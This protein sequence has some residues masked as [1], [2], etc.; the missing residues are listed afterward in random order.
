MCY[1]APSNTLNTNI[2]SFSNFV[3]CP[4]PSRYLKAWHQG[5]LRNSTAQNSQLHS[6]VIRHCLASVTR[7]SEET[8]YRGVTGLTYFDA[9]GDC[10]SKGA[11]VAVVKDGKFTAAEKQIEVDA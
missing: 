2:C 1:F 8:A 6:P 5:T 7:T 10:Y 9:E 11:H 4:Q 3:I